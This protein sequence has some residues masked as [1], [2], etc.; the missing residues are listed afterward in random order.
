MVDVRS[1]SLR[2]PTRSRVTF[3]NVPALSRPTLSR[4]TLISADHKLD[5]VS[6]SLLSRNYGF[7]LVASLS[8]WQPRLTL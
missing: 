5:V 3:P 7:K 6:G 1:S 8:V 2:V 4:P